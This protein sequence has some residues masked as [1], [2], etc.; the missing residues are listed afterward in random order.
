MHYEQG[1]KNFDFKIYTKFLLFLKERILFFKKIFL[2]N[3]IKPLAS[4]LKNNFY[5]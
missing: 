3:K 1:I 4:L 5:L 2:K